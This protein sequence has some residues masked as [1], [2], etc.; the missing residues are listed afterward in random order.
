MG[1]E[2]KTQKSK[3]QPDHEESYMPYKEFLFNF[4]QDGLL[5]PPPWWGQVRLEVQTGYSGGIID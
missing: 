5:P 2:Q 3:E 4:M 1:Q